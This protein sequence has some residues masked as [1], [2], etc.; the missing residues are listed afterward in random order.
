MKHTVPS[1]VLAGL[2]LGSALALLAPAS[3]AAAGAPVAIT[4][5]AS[6]LPGAVEP[7]SPGDSTD[8]VVSGGGRYVLFSSTSRLVPADTDNV[9]DVYRKDLLT[10]GLV[11]ANV[12]IDGAQASQSS[13]AGAI[14]PDGRYVAFW[15]WATNLVPNDTN[16]KA[17]VFVR[18]LSSGTTERVSVSSA[19]AQ[20]DGASPPDQDGTMDLSFDGRY[21]AFSSSAKN[22]GTDGDVNSDIFVRDRLAGTTELISVNSAEASANGD[23]YRPSMS[24]DGR[25]VA[26]QS[27]AANLVASDTNASTDVFVRD[28]QAGTTVRASLQDGSAQSPTGGAEPVISDSGE[29]VVFTSSSKLNAIDPNSTNDVYV[30]TVPDAST[31]VGSVGTDGWAAG[32]SQ[33][34]TISGDGTTVAYQSTSPKALAGA[35]GW[36][37]LYTRKLTTTTRVTVSSAGTIATGTSSNPSL[38]TTGTVVAL[39]SKSPNLVVGDTG[40][41]DVFFRRPVT[42]GPFNAVDAFVQRQATD[43][44]GN[45]QPATVAPLAARV[46][47]GGRPSTSW[48]TWP[49]PPP[50]PASGRRSSGCTSP[51]SGGCPIWVA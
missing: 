32:L 24:A 6:V 19:E 13:T 12:T 41:K 10:D 50:S 20:A 3:P 14:S 18:D 40:M 5:R 34:P 28:R 30:R 48:S 44:L 7:A 4:G 46:R 2:V 25:Y 17:D 33:D 16:G 27:G 15:S 39:D 1:T 31:V 42:F 47:A 43:F 45:A 8:A 36:E 51:T 21:V 11:R 23:S 38:S 26:F 29:K 22:L 37:H 35:N 9:K 49:T